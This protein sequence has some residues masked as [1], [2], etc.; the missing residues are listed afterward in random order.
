MNG[1]SVVQDADN[2]F[3]MAIW[4]G[5]KSDDATQN[6]V[7]SQEQISFSS[8]KTVTS[9]TAKIVIFLY[10]IAKVH[11]AKNTPPTA[12]ISEMPRSQAP[13]LLRYL[14]FANTGKEET[15]HILVEKIIQTFASNPIISG[16]AEGEELRVTLDS[17]SVGE[18]SSLCIALGIS[19]RLSV[20]FTVSSA[21]TL[22]AEPEKKMVPEALQAAGSPEDAKERYRAVFATFAGQSEG[23]KKSNLLRKQWMSQDFKKVTE[24][25]I[26]EM[27]TAMISLGDKLELNLPTEPF[28]KPLNLLASYY[29]HQA[30]QLRALGKISQ[31]QKENVEMINQWIKDVRELIKSLSKAE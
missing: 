27:Q 29:E 18:L 11:L 15:D 17:L 21:M 20:S 9:K 16:P 7:T 14:V 4:N 24:M 30:E 19:L 10:S 1:R 31:K 2:A 22:E 5:L 3:A 25:S 6:I 26:D 13:L 12:K 23:W 8:P 28:I